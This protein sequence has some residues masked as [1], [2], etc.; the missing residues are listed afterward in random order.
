MSADFAQQFVG[1][2]V[3]KGATRKRT[4]LTASTLVPPR[5]NAMSGPNRRI[6]CDAEQCLTPP[7]IIGW[8][9]TPSMAICRNRFVGGA[10]MFSRHALR[11]HAR[12]RRTPPAPSL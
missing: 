6:V 3:V 1:V 11:R 7:L 4:S 12:F 5:P 9:S 10:T 2:A 8:M